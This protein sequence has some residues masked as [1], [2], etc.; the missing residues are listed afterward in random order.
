MF[1]AVAML[2]VALTVAYVLPNGETKNSGRAPGGGLSR[3]Q[4]AKT[5]HPARRLMRPAAGSRAI[6][7]KFLQRVGRTFC[8]ASTAIFPTT[9]SLPSPQA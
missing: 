6:P 2:A 4:A 5:H 7:P 9:A 3:S 8:C 1:G